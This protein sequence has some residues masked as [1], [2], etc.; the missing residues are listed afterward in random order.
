MLIIDGRQLDPKNPVFREFALA[1][2][3]MSVAFVSF[4][5]GVT[6]EEVYD[7]FRFLSRETAGISSETLPQI[8]AE[9]P[10]LHIL[11]RAARLPR[12]RLRRGAGRNGR[13]S[14]EYLLERYIKALLEGG[15]PAD[16]V[17]A[18]VENVEPGTLAVLMNQAGGEIAREESYDTVVSSYL[19]GGAG[20]A[21]HGGRSA[22]A[23]DVH[24]R[25]APG[26]QAAVPLL[27]G[28][29]GLARP[30]GAESGAR[31]G[32]R[33]QHHRLLRRRSTGT[34]WRCPRHSAP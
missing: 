19:R 24:R 9:Y 31:G 20:R 29:G 2:S 15:L 4:V 30:G 34:A 33:G 3:R 26:A 14:D 11:D 7:F 32:G 10:L 5:K 28:E 18:V 6:R 23:D 1:L 12:L 27:L 16:G 13:S 17:Q 22:A 25:A 21:R 8:L